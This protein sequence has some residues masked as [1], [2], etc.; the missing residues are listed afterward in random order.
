[1]EIVKNLQVVEKA[2][3]IIDS[4]QN[5][6]HLKVAEKYCDLYY[7]MFEDFANYRIL[8]HRLNDKGKMF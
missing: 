1:M 6:I 7:E 5:E 2:K 3:R 4:C 8:I